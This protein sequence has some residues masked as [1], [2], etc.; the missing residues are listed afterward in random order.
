MI[1]RNREVDGTDIWTMKEAG[2]WYILETNY[3]HWKPPLFVD[4]RRTPANRCMQK[5][6]QNGVGIPGL[7]D[8]LSSKPVLN[9]VVCFKVFSQFYVLFSVCLFL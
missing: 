4:D 1:T 9:K 2:G 7:F 6:S 3:D 8:V 5:L